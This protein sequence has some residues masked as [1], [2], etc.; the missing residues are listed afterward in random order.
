MSWINALCLL[1][2]YSFIAYFWLNLLKVDE[3]YNCIIICH[4]QLNNEQET[5]ATCSD[6]EAILF[7]S[8]ASFWYWNA[9]HAYNLKGSY[10]R[11][12]EADFF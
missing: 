1:L 12:L 11:L 8:G 2:I 5:I 7:A 4:Q 10:L 3:K 9:K 6:V